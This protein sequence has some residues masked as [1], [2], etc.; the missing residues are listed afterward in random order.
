[1]SL[2]QLAHVRN[3]GLLLLSHG[4]E[5]C[6]GYQLIP[7]RQWG[8]DRGAHIRQTRSAAIVFPVCSQHFYFRASS[9]LK[10]KLNGEP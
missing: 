9:S 4:C 5:Y 8:H 3:T 2:Q 1:V 7:K 10:K 6:G